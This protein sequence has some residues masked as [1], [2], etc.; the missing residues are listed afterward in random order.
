MLVTTQSPVRRTPFGRVAV[1]IALLVATITA[2]CGQQAAT[3]TPS[4]SAPPGSAS[5][6][7]AAPASTTVPLAPGGLDAGTRYV[8]EEIG[9]AFTPDVDG[10]FAVVQQEGEGALTREDVTIWVSLPDTV[11]ATDNVTRAP[12]PTDAEGFLDAIDATAA[13]QI[14]DR[15]PFESGGLTG[16]EALAV[17]DGACE[18][19][20]LLQTPSGDFC[21][22]DGTHP[23]FVLDLG[24]RVVLFSAERSLP[25]VDATM[26]IAGP[27]IDSLE[28]AP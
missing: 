27:I 3:T 26:E 7:A 19:N 21:L 11:L 28:A 2:G 18:R 9:I 6:S 1:F 4:A 24:D 15:R 8:I 16:V 13:L 20:P 17:A 23:W 25:D 10:W 5:P 22:E 12:A 14:T